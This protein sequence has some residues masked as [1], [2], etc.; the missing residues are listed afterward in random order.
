[1]PL[2]LNHGFPLV[3]WGWEYLGED[4]SKPTCGKRIDFL[5]RRHAE[6][7]TSGKTTYARAGQRRLL[8]WSEG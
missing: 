2:Y 3:A 1:M 8:R 6:M 7:S 5:Y 4:S